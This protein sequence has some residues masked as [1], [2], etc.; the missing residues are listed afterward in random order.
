M[1]FSCDRKEM[2]HTTFRI[3]R[4]GLN[5]LNVRF[6]SDRCQMSQFLGQAPQEVELSVGIRLQSGL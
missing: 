3:K 4:T 6:L 2:K 5:G 1:S